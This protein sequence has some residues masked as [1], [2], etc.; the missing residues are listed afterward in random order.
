MSVPS[1]DD[2]R[3]SV[4][5]P[6]FNYGHHLSEAVETVLA[7][8]LQG[9]EIII[10]DDGSTDDS[11]AVAQRLID[12]HPEAS[13]RLISQPN[14]GSP[15]HSRNVGIATCAA[16]YSGSQSSADAENVRRSA[17]L[18]ATVAANCGSS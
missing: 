18:A 5:I 4:V 14:S 1:S 7:Q 11:A 6:C 10:V 12:A 16:A 9:F 8:T 2:V 17:A 13:V 15:G 3:V